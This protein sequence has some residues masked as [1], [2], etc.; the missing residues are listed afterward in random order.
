LNKEFILQQSEWLK[1]YWE[2]QDV[3]GK[4][5]KLTASNPK[6]SKTEKRSM[7]GLNIEYEVRYILSVY[8]DD[9]H[10]RHRSEAA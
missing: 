10:Y 3:L 2:Q 8:Y 7:S 1:L 4:T 5:S 6:S 9:M